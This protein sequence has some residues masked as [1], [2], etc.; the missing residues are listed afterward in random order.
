MEENSTS[1]NID[2][3]DRKIL[4]CL[5]TDGR[6]SNAEIAEKVNV[7]PATC[8]RRTQRL[9][10]DGIISSVT[11]QVR[12]DAVDLSVLV[13][14]GAVLERSTPESFAEFEAAIPQFPFILECQCVAGDFDYFLKVRV[15]DISDFN[16]LHRAQLLTLPGVRQL[17]SFFVLKEVIENAPLHF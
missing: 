8:H 10:E 15:K 5:Q 17:R 16:T 1:H 9:F 6:M 7:S 3:I 13:L 12:P 2:K 11:A 14:V 4:K